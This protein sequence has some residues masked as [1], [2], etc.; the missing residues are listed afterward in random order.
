MAV[1]LPRSGLRSV[2]SIAVLIIV[3]ITVSC[4]VFRRSAFLL[5]SNV[6]LR[7]SSGTV[8]P[9]CAAFA[10]SFSVPFRLFL[11]R[12]VCVAGPLAGCPG[13]SA[14]SLGPDDP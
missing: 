5:L 7:P 2:G 4:A 3:L 14:Q 10:P 1:L 6:S 8:V 11:M 12:S 13:A 9:S